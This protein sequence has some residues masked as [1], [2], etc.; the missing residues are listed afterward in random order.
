MV[1]RASRFSVEVQCGGVPHLAH[2]TNSGRLLDIIFPGSACLCIPK[3]PAKTTLRL[4]GAPI[5]DRWAVLVDPGE[6][7]R[8]FVNA[9]GAGLVP[10]LDGW[11]ISRA[12][13]PCGESRIDL[14][15]RR[16]QDTGYVE[17]KSAALL[18][19]GNVGSFPDC[20]TVRGRKHVR[21]MSRLAGN[22]RSIIVFLV[23]HYNAES[24]APNHT[25]DAAFTASLA[26][27]RQNG[28]E[29]RAVKMCLERNGDLEMADPDLPCTT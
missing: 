21:T 3:K 23:Q 15:I 7:S 13:V 28:V 16:G 5:S 27:A 29:V 2:L 19:D 17:I 9:A 11:E 25:G 24:F 4:V 8:G 1:R 6:Q 14:E 10:W 26:R 12:E 18:L 20:P 22:H